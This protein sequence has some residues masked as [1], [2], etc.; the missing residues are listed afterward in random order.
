MVMVKMGEYNLLKVIK[1]KPMGVFV[2][3]GEAGILMPRRFVPEGTR[4]GD[5]LEVFLYHDGE[6]RPGMPANCTTRSAIAPIGNCSV[7]APSAQAAAGMP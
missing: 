5:E 1:E 6:G 2:D 4:I 7:T 3:D